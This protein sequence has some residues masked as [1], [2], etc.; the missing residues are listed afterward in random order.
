M[1]TYYIFKIN[2]GCNTLYNKKTSNIYKILNR[3][4][5]LD[6]NETHKAINIY[7]KI[8]KPINKDRIDYL[9][10]KKHMNDLWKCT[11]GIAVEKDINNIE[12]LFDLQ[13]M[14]DYIQE[15]NYTNEFSIYNIIQCINQGHQLIAVGHL[16]PEKTN[17]DFELD[18]YMYQ[19]VG[20][21]LCSSIAE[22]LDVPY[23]ERKIKGKWC[24]KL[25]RDRK[26]TRLNSSH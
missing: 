22:C 14:I 20:S 9:I 10:T 18:S 24:K 13:K 11:I 4:N 1:R 16:S 23:I 6:I 5:D 17:G 21:E 26:S 7:K 3:I 19:S 25:V 8:I 2:N 15:E 12:F